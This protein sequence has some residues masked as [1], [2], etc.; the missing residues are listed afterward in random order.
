MDI[1]QT[2]KLVSN[3][4]DRSLACGGDDRVIEELAEKLVQQSPDRETAREVAKAAISA[5][6][7]ARLLR[8]A[9][10]AGELSN[11]EVVHYYSAISSYRKAVQKLETQ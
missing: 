9:A 4:I 11:A 1:H 7:R 5:C 6:R 3:E 10:R 8:D 2:L